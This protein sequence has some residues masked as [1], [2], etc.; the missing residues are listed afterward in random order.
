LKPA[1]NERY[2]SSLMKGIAVLSLLQEDPWLGASE[3]AQR[4]RVHRSTALRLAEI[5]RSYDL[6][7]RDAETKKYRLGVRLWELGAQA[8]AKVDLQRTARPYLEQL[9]KATGHSAQVAVLDGQGVA[10]L[11]RSEPDDSQFHT[12][13]GPSLPAHALATGKVL[14]AYLSPEQ[15]RQYLIHL[16]RFTP[17]TITSHLALD[18]ACE[19]IRR[20]G[21]CINDREWRIDGGGVAAPVFGRLETCIAAI[22]IGFPAQVSNE[23]LG[24]LVSLVRGTA[25]SV[26]RAMGADLTRGRGRIRALLGVKDQTA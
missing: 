8:V 4:L 25:H 6:V 14:L 16:K 23:M 17:Y 2:E 20:N 11:E 9:A 10:Y 3:L 26:S 5:L 7:R 12:P 1:I 24:V 13:V 19:L 22:G 21:Y 15:R 18:E